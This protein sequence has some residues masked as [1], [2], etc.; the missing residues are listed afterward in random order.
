[1]K[2]AIMKK[3]SGFTLTELMITLAIVGI[4]ITVGVPSMQNFI[5]GNR[6][7]AA[8]N[9][10]LSALNIARSEAIKLNAQVSLCESNN[11][12]TCSTT[13]AGKMAGLYLW[14]QMVMVLPQPVWQV[15]PLQR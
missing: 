2:M 6:L 12:S 8:S 3:Y 15:V 5:Q 11:G 10:L 9:E 7:I 13:E 4:L 14:M 1:M